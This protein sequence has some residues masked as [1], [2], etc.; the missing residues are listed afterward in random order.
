[1]AVKCPS[2]WVT[3]AT[4]SVL[5]SPNEKLEEFTHWTTSAEHLHGTSKHL[6]WNRRAET[7]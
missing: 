2:M 5:T 6:C 1:M 4:L 7:L 3:L